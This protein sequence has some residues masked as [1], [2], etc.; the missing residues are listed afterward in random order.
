MFSLII[1]VHVI[2]CAMLILLVLIQQ[3]RGGETLA[4]PGG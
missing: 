3:G 2:I 4:V 1:A